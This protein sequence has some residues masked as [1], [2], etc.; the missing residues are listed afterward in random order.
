MEE[1]VEIK[2]KIETLNTDLDI[3]LKEFYNKNKEYLDEDGCIN[4]NFIDK[5]G[6][7]DVYNNW[8]KIK[9][10]K[11]YIDNYEGF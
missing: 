3:F 2:N 9:Y 6:G 11:D 8:M 10:L 5:I 4:K 1:L 7:I